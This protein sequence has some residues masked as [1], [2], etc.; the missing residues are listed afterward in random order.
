[1]A[2]TATLWQLAAAFFEAQAGRLIIPDV[3][4]KRMG[5]R[6]LAQLAR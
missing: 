3:H 5:S 2:S 1:M 4:T 6:L